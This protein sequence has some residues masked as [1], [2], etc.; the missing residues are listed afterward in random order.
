MGYTSVGKLENFGRREPFE[1]M[2]RR[3]TKRMGDELHDRTVR[4]TPVAKPPPGH[5]A[6]WLESR[7]R[8]PETL[9]KSWRVGE[10]TVLDQGRR[11][12]IDVYTTD[13]IAPFVEWPTMPH[14][15]VPKRP[16]GWLRFWDKL[17]NTIYARIVHHTG[18]KGSFMLTTAAAETQA[19]WDEIG[20]EEL[21]KWAR[22]QASLVAA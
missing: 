22:E 8:A 4:H 6:E 17:G 11:M 20:G 13:R 10:V 18:T 5:E 7:K 12:T 16:G 2:C 1:R 3:A 14:I 19:L 21:D 9:K 15:I